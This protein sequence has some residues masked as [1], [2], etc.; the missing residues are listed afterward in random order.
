MDQIQV[1]L[2]QGWTCEI[3]TRLSSKKFFNRY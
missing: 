1:N 2:K 3:K